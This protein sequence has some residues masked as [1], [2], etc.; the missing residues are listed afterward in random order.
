MRTINING[1]KIDSA[2]DKELIFLDSAIKSGKYDVC[3]KKAD[4]IREEL[5]KRN[6]GEEELIEDVEEYD[7]SDQTV[8][9]LTNDWRILVMWTG[10]LIKGGKW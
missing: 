4:L 10:N 7:P 3:Y 5:E 6:L 9:Q 1:D 2:S 8:L